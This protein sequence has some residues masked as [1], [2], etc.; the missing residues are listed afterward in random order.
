MLLDTRPPDIPGVMFAALLS[1]PRLGP[2]SEYTTIACDPTVA[3][4]TGINASQEIVGYCG[5]NGD[6]AFTKGFVRFRNGEL[7]TFT[8]PQAALQTLALD[9]NDDG[10]ITASYA[11]M[12]GKYRGFVRDAD[13]TFTE[14]DPPNS[15]G[16]F[17]ASINSTGVAVNSSGQVTG[18]W[19]DA[20]DLDH[21]FTRDTSGN[22]TTCDAPGAAYYGTR[23]AS[24][25][26]SGELAGSAINSVEHCFGFTQSGTN[27]RV[28]F[29]GWYSDASVHQRGFFRDVPPPVN[30]P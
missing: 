3:V 9:L 26:D 4:P 21:G 29:Y 27:A 20:N 7:M 18:W 17:P 8:A 5:N 14:F 19:S 11:E 28:N 6:N 25:N 22:S 10:A 1:F 15:T 30:E 16:T 13:G 2:A 24:I 12:S 23:V